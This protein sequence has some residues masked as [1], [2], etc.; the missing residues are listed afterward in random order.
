MMLLGLYDKVR[1]LLGLD[2]IYLPIIVREG[3][4]GIMRV[5][6]EELAAYFA[7]HPPVKQG[8]WQNMAPA[9]VL[10]EFAR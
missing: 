1:G 4:L 8:G 5:T 6:E 10:I 7:K 9:R 3:G 2:P